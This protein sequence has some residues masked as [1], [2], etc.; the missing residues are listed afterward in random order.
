MVVLPCCGSVGGG[1]R[2]LVDQK[3]GVMKPTAFS[4]RLQ[5]QSIYL[6]LPLLIR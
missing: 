5:R 6:P 4:T 1:S 2:R 3:Q